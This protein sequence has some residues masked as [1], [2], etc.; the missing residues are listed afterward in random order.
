MQPDRKKPMGMSSFTRRAV[1]VDPVARLGG[2]GSNQAA[3]SCGRPNE[4]RPG[5]RFPL[6]LRSRCTLRSPGFESGNAELNRIANRS[7][8]VNL[9]SRS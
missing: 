9:D 8:S 4:V 3:P 2:Q 1:F 6:D 7:E 5:R